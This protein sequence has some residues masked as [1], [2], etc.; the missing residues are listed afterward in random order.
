MKPYFGMFK[1]VSPYGI[2]T[3]PITGASGA[4]HS[5]IDLVGITSKEV[6]SPVSGTVLRSRMVTDKSNRTWEWGNYVSVCGDDGYLYYLCHLAER[7]AE[8]GERIRAGQIIG[9]EG[10]TGRSTGSHLHLEIRNSAGNAVDPAPVLGICGEAG[11]IEDGGNLPS[12]WA[13]ETVNRAIADGV[14]L[15]NELGDLMLDRQC[16]R[17]EVLV[18]L[19]RIMENFRKEADI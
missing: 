11:G 4:W 7:R 6:R 12:P 18:F 2:R 1:T 17:E 16:T 3:D 19:Y 10:S 13:A 9:I 8:A 15:G 5:G 14:L